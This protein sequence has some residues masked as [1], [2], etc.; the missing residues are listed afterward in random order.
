[1]SSFTFQRCSGHA[2]DA[3]AVLAVLKKINSQVPFE[4]RVNRA[5]TSI[6]RFQTG[7]VGTLTHTILLH[8]M[9]CLF[10]WVATKGI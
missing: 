3:I 7:A 10:G 6:F 8:E 2:K 9:V 1:M 5:T 4:R